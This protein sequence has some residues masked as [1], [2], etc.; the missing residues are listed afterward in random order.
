M[1]EFLEGGDMPV[2]KWRVVFHVSDGQLW[3]RALKNITNFLREVGDAAAQVEVVANAAA[4]TGYFMDG[5][6]LG[7]MVQLAERGVVF[8][9]CRN[10]LKEHALENSALPPFVQVV[11]AGV[12]EL[13]QKQAA[14]YAYIKP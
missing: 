14:G 7:Q 8:K 9:A 5:E 3:P 13:V 6:E 2:E 10:A 11:P 4:V 1:T 12:A